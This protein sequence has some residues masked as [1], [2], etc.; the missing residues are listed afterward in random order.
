MRY[1]AWQFANRQDDDVSTLHNFVLAM[2]GHHNNP[3]TV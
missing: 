1:D 3:I 2:D